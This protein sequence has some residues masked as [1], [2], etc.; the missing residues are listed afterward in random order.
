M[1]ELE[2]DKK[3]YFMKVEESSDQLIVDKNCQSKWLN[4]RMVTNGSHNG[5]ITIR[6]KEMAEQLY[7][8]LGQVL[9]K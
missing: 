1:T 6:S 8:M 3:H 7:F 5:Q 9:E 4:I 2:F